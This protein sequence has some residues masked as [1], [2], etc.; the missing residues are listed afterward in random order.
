MAV[1]T[2][3]IVAVLV[4]ALKEMAPLVIERVKAQ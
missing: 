1:I 3:A 4:H 2:A